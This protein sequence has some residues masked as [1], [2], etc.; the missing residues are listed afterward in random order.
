MFRPL[1][2]IAALLPA[3]VDAG[4]GDQVPIYLLQVPSSTTTVFI[5]E[6]STSSLYRF[7]FGSDGPEP[8]DERY[9]SIGQNGVGKQRPWDRRTPLGIYFVVDELDTSVLHEKYGP[10]A[11]PLDYPNVVDRINRRGGDGIWIHGVL[12]D[13]GRRPPLDTDGCIALPNAELLALRDQFVPSTTPVIITREI[14]WASAADVA[15]LRHDLSSALDDW[16]ASVRDGDL[17]RYLSLYSA[18]FAYRGMDRSKW[19]AFRTSTFSVPIQEF[20]ISDILLL[21]DPE[22]QGLY[23]SRFQQ[24]V[25]DNDRRVTTT[26]RLYWRRSESGALE[27]VAE[28]NG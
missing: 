16:T 18:D 24:T 6:A 2:L 1:L 3:F 22:E 12:P 26:K 7:E 25:V 11:F 15:A 8:G 10:T 28:D 9:M 27:V 19:A 4:P 5:A 13:G 21:A 23:L 17:H 14:Q 20:E